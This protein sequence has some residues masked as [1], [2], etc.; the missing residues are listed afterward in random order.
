MAD[1]KFQIDPASVS[2][3]NKTL[4]DLFYLQ[5]R[6]APNFLNKKGYS[7]ALKARKYTPKTTATQIEAGLTKDIEVS[8]K[9]Q[10]HITSTGKISAAKKYIVKS[11]SQ[12]S[13]GE[14]PL[15]VAIIQSRSNPKSPNYRGPSPWYGVPRALGA[16]RMNE[17]IRRFLGARRS[18]AGFYGAGW[19]AAIMGLRRAYK[20][21]DLPPMSDSDAKKMKNVLRL[22]SFVPATETKPEVTI[23]NDAISRFDKRGNA[24]VRIGEKAL[25]KAMDEEASS[26]EAEITR[27]M[28]EDAR[29]L[30]IIVKGVVG[31]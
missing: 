8:S 7:I 25:M 31:F 1:V 14:V 17:A 2:K 27:R 5:K 15:M 13:T 10:E 3:F 23:I 12:Q 16:E 9:M 4:S 24:V 22:G 6:S 30:G 19:L 18:S 26:M 20:G 21:N 28:A 29:K 11:F